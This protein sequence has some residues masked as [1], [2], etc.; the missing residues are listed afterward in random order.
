MT[1]T[2]SDEAMLDEIELGRA[3]PG[4]LA[5][6]Q[7]AVDVRLKAAGHV[8]VCRCLTLQLSEGPT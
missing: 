5:S 1:H 7:L 4:R 3:I 2:L 8:A 6:N